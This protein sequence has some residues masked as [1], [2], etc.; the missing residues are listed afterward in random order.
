MFLASFGDVQFSPDNRDE[1]K[2]RFYGKAVCEKE[3]L[4][5]FST[6]W[7]TRRHDVTEKYLGYSPRCWPI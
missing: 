4:R 5:R 1:V 7:F 3:A 2:T 6:V